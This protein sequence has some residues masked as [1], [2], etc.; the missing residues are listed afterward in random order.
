MANIRNPS[1]GTEKDELSLTSQDPA[2]VLYGVNPNNRFIP[3]KVTTDGALVIGAPIELEAG[4]LEIGAVELKNYNT[5]DRVYVSPNHEV[6]TQSRLY[7][8]LGN[9]LTSTAGALN[10][11]VVSTVAASTP[12]NV[13]GSNL[14]PVA[15][16]TTVV[17][18]TVPAGRT[19]DITGFTGWGDWDAEFLL[20]V[21]INV[22]GG[23]RSSP[24]DRMIVVPYGVAT[25]TATAGQVVSV[26]AITNQADAT[27]MMKA[28]LLGS[29]R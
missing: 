2:S 28:N 8:Y 10:V 19:F 4:D 20:K 18:Y 13:F 21:D 24:S 3:V 22:V 7:D 15:T 23:G 25:I 5:D 17:S 27:Q 26:T 14:A 1:Y 6:L 9:G 29:L 12:I 16:E 11:S